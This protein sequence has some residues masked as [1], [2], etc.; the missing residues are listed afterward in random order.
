MKKVVFE[1][2]DA[3]IISEINDNSLIGVIWNNDAKSIAVLNKD[4][5]MLISKFD[6]NLSGNWAMKT[7]KELIT[8]AIKN[9]LKNVFLFDT[10][11]ELFNWFYKN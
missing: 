8:Q 3:V 11:E 9:G 1:A 4:G 10:K 2:V 7:K 6:L 5:F